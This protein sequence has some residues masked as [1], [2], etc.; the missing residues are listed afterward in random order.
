MSLLTCF[1]QFVFEK[2]RSLVDR[3]IMTLTLFK[4]LGHNSLET[5]STEP[6]SPNLHTKHASYKPFKASS[7]A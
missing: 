3:I 4:C 2:S 5:L 1:F 6:L 7:Y